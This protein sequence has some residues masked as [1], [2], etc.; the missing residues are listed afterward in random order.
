[1]TGDADQRRVV[2]D[3][4]VVRVKARFLGQSSFAAIG[5]SLKGLEETA[6]AI[7]RKELVMLGCHFHIQADVG[8]ESHCSHHSESYGLC[9]G[10][11]T[12]GDGNEKKMLRML[13]LMLMLML[14]KEEFQ[15]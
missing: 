2:V 14:Q 5:L 9:S 13:M 3:D 7:G 11:A 12:F 1:V 15:E 8:Q 10:V 6:I 4:E